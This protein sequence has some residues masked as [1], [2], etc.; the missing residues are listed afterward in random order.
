VRADRALR[1][2]SWESFT[3]WSVAMLILTAAAE[4]A[5]FLLR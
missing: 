3:F 1:P 5:G 2:E 4:I